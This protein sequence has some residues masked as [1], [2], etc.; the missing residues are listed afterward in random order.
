V[1]DEIADDFDL[2]DILVRDYDVCSK[3]SVLA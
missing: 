3:C 1:A 2:V